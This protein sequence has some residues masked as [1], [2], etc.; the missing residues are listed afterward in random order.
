MPKISIDHKT[1][2]AAPEALAKIK[3]FFETDKGMHEMDSKIKCDFN[4]AT[5]KGKVTGSN[6]KA[7]VSV[8][9][10]GPGSGSGSKVNVVID[11]PLIMTPFKGKVEETLKRKLAKYLA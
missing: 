8:L 2:L 6:F 3:I 7:D 9:A 11:L 1:S 10:E 5:L 4:E